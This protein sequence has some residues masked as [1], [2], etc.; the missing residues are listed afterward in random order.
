MLRSSFYRNLRRIADQFEW[1][2]T[3]NKCIRGYR[4]G[5]AYCPI[6]AVYYSKTGIRVDMTEANYTYIFDTPSENPNIT[7]AA[8]H[9]EDKLS[10]E[11]KIIRK[12]LLKA[13]NLG[14]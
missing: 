7:R 6:T 11:E 3:R 1:K 14:E 13:L 5:K 4:D 2:I 12:T 9:A 8:D 10:K